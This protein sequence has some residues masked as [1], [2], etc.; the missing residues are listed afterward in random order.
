MTRVEIALCL[1]LVAV[2]VLFVVFAA[3][4][5]PTPAPVYCPCGHWLGPVWHPCGIK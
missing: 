3:R 4:K 1:A 5:P 2:L